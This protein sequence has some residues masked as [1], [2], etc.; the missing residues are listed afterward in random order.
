M[1]MTFALRRQEIVQE[2]P[3][4]GDFLE[5]WPALRME[6]QV[7]AEFHRITNVNLRNQFFSELDRHTLRRHG[8]KVSEALCEILRIC[9]LQEVQ[10]VHMKRS[11]SSPPIIPAQRRLTGQTSPTHRLLLSAWSLKALQVKLI[12]VRQVL[13]FWWKKVL[14]GLDDGKPLKPCILNLKK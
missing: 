5:K 9:D 12:S 8:I 13:L 11:P 10:D 2:N 3:L 7:C 14:M 6:S 4:V 1:Q